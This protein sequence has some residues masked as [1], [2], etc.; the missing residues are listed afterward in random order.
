MGFE[1]FTESG[2]SFKTRVSIRANGQIGLSHGAVA[3]FGLGRYQYAV[4]F[5]DKET[6]QI[7]IQPTNSAEE[8]GAYKLNIKGSGAAISA[9]AFMDYCGIDHG[10]A[11]RHSA[12][13]DEQRGMVIID[14]T[15]GDV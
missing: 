4:L 13:W 1:R 3:K 5:Y 12:H 6:K 9:L 10:Q 14:L 15:S 2:R 11:R 7:G 8:S